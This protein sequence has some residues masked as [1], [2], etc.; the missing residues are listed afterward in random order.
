MQPVA[1]PPPPGWRNWLGQVGIRLTTDDGII[2][3][4][5][6]GGGVAATT[7]INEL[8]H[9]KLVGLDTLDTTAI[10][11]TMYDQTLPYGRKGLAIMAISG[12]DLAIWDAR[13]K[14]A[15]ASMTE[16]LGGTNRAR[17]PAYLTNPT[18][19]VE[20]VEPGYAGIKIAVPPGADDK[21][22]CDRLER[23]RGDLGPKPMLMVDVGMAWD[24][25]TSH[26]FLD[27]AAH[28]DVAWLEEPLRP[29]DICG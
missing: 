7:I 23:L 19:P 20:E 22:A 4:G 12:V 27:C 3:Y 2:A 9:M 28:L 25:R 24:L 6:S 10:W 11:Q 21:W 8:L 5:V 14:L 13:A 18:W 15:H 29:D 26:A 16:Y 17:I 1:P